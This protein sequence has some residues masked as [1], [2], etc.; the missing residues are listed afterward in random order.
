M[1]RE[2]TRKK[3]MR[4]YFGLEKESLRVTVPDFRLSQSPHPFESHPYITKDFCEAQT[5]I[6]T[7][8]CDTIE[9]LCQTLHVLNSEVL[10]TLSRSDETLWNHSNPPAGIRESEIRTA[11]FEGGDSVKEAYRCYLREKYGA[12]K[13]LLS[14]IHNNF[15]FTDEA[16][17]LLC[18]DTGR[19]PEEQYLHLAAC[20]LKYAWLITWLTA[21]SPSVETDVSGAGRM[22]VASMRCSSKGYWNDFIPVLNYEDLDGYVKSME[23]LMDSGRL[24]S[25]W[26]LYLPVRLKPKGENSLDGL[27]HGISHIELRMLD[28]NPL[29]PDGVCPEDLHFLHLLLLWFSA[30]ETLCFDP[31]AQICAVR[32]MKRSALLDENRIWIEEPAGFY[33]PVRDAAL[34]ILADM[35]LF[36]EEWQVPEILEIIA[37]ERRKVLDPNLRYASRVLRECANCSEFQAIIA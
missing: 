31:A 21:A 32:N 3:M 33:L 16:M 29:M 5:E 11:H 27:R 30:A 24:Y 4:G 10:Q 15:S 17:Q 13:M 34:Q 2:E 8:V 1:P 28:L 18:G 23:A 19:S 12:R 6:V 35:D 26:E 36:F 22:R 7:P 20:S 14:G 25:P 37:Y 9:E